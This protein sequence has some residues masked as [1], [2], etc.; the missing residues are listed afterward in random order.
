MPESSRIWIA[1]EHGFRIQKRETEVDYKER[2]WLMVDVDERH[3]FC[4]S[5]NTFSYQQ[6]GDVWFL[7]STKLETAR[8]DFLMGKNISSPE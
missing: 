6:I 7:K 1:P 3:P 5:R 4:Q 2:F 8:I